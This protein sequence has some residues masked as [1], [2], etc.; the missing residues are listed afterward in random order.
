MDS[1]VCVTGCQVRRSSVMDPET[2]RT[3]WFSDYI[4]RI[5]PPH[6]KPCFRGIVSKRIMF[7]SCSLLEV[8]RSLTLEAT[9]ERKVCERAL[10]GDWGAA[11]PSY[12]RSLVQK[13]PGV[14][15]LVCAPRVFHEGL[16][17]SNPRRV[18]SD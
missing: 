11:F 14:P 7:G 6:V 13:T 4:R 18:V 16:F 9:S 2:R 12:A 17:E 1:Y 10:S 8:A 5:W 15:I 3:D